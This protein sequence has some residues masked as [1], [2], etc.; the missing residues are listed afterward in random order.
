MC[1]WCDAYVAAGGVIQRCPFGMSGFDPMPRRIRHARM[2]IA[3]VASRCGF[4]AIPQ[5]AFPLVRDGLL[6]MRIARVELV[7]SAARDRQPVNLATIAKRVGISRGSALA[8]A[9]ILVDAQRMTVERGRKFVLFQ[10]IGETPPHWKDFFK[11]A[12]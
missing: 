2:Q 5:D 6:R 7:W 10:A 8:T 3:A 4:V 12:A 1:G 11:E 9:E